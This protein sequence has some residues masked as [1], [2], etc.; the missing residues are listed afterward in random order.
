MAQAQAN[1]PGDGIV[2]HEMILAVKLP[3]T[4]TVAEAQGIWRWQALSVPKFL[5]EVYYHTID[6]NTRTSGDSTDFSG[7][8]EILVDLFWPDRPNSQNGLVSIDSSG[9]VEGTGEGTLNLNGLSYIYTP[10]DPNVTPV[11]MYPN[12]TGDVIIGT[13]FDDDELDLFVMVK[14]RD[15]PASDF[16]DLVNL[17]VVLENNSASLSWNEASKF[18]LSASSGLSQW[19]PVFDTQGEDSHTDP[20]ISES[21]FYRVERVTDQ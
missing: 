10:A 11:T 1:N 5:K 18:C 14:I 4:L 17:Q 7:D 8:N 3:S 9:M 6:E 19:E 12:A 16:D 20:T 21:E 2:S 15:E 13:G